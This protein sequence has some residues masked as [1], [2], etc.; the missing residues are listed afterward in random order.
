MPNFHFE[1]DALDRVLDRLALDGPDWFRARVAE[2]LALQREHYRPIDEAFRLVG[3]SAP[4]PT[5]GK[6]EN[7]VGVFVPGVEPDQNRTY[8]ERALYGYAVILRDPTD[9]ERAACPFGRSVIRT[10]EAI[11]V[12]AI[13]GGGSVYRPFGIVEH[14]VVC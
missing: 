2:R 3:V 4:R 9:V 12:I 6:R 10:F 5:R 14:F 11:D 7:P 13:G 8:R 1:R